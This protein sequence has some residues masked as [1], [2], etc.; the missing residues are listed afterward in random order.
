MGTALSRCYS[1]HIV[2]PRE[3]RAR[4]CVLEEQ[5]KEVRREKEQNEHLFSLQR[6]KHKEE[7]AKFR[8]KLEEEE[9][10]VSRLQAAGAAAVAP[11]PPPPATAV[12]GG[13]EWEWRPRM[14]RDYM[15][16]RMREEKARKEVA[17]E[18]WKQLYLAIKTELDELILRT[19]EGIFAISL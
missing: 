13:K 14:E 15:V 12:F 7:V 9:E 19:N 5:I 4:I 1:K 10:I 11:P 3:L 2:E 6:R 16:E 18:K 17:V 8:R